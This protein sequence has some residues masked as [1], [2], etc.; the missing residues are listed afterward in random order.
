[1]SKQVHLC[2]YKGATVFF[3]IE[4]RIP[5]MEKKMKTN[6]IKSLTFHFELNSSCLKNDEFNNI[7]G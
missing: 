1:M 4:V 7:F 2:L 6:I 5:G 3:L